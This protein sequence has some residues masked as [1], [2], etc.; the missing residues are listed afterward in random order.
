[1]CFLF[2]KPAV[3]GLERNMNE[4]LQSGLTSNNNKNNQK[5]NSGKKII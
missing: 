4:I 5:E 1:M 3:T 2:R